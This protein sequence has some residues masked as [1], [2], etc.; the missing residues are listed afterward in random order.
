MTAK[1]FI[2]YRLISVMILAGIVSASISINNYILPIVA[3]IIFLI[4]FHSMKK[5]VSEVLEDERDYNL[6]G[7]ASRYAVS[8]FSGMASIIIIVLFAFRSR[9]PIYEIVGLTLAYSICALLLLI[10]ILFKY[11]QK[12]EK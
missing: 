5:Q 4:V 9:N 8:I 10:S 2:V 1:R 12:Y 11:F 3:V 6:A 7:K